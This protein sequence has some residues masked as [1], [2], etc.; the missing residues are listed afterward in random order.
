MQ[1]LAITDLSLREAPLAPASGG[2]GIPDAPTGKAIHVDPEAEAEADESAFDLDAD[3]YD[4]WFKID[5]YAVSLRRVQA[6]AYT[7][8]S[9]QHAAAV[10]FEPPTAPPI[11]VPVVIPEGIGP[12]EMLCTRIFFEPSS[13]AR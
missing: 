9:V 12:G 6:A 7:C 1:A 8:P 4:H 11:T 3:L 10:V 13:N 5:G 2:E